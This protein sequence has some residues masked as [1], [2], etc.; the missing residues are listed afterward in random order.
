MYKVNSI[1]DIEKIEVEGL[2][3]VNNNYVRLLVGYV[4]PIEGEF[5]SWHKTKLDAIVAVN[6]Q[7]DLKIQAHEFHLEQLKQEKTRF[8]S[9]FYGE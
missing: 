6:N 4:E 2:E 8:N 9:Q 5:Y 1:N 7:I 3:G